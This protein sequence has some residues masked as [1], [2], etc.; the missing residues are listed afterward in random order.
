MFLRSWGLMACFTAIPA[1]NPTAGYEL[2]W[3]DRIRWGNIE[4][5]TSGKDE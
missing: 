3:T 1:D 2:A 5:A 4:E